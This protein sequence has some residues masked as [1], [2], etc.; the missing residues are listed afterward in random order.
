M[1]QPS[2]VRRALPHYEITSVEADIEESLVQ[3]EVDYEELSVKQLLEQ[4]QD[5]YSVRDPA[6]EQ[7]ARI[8][9][10][11]ITRLSPVYKENNQLELFYD[12]AGLASR[13][14]KN[15][16][17]IVVQHPEVPLQFRLKKVR[18]TKWKVVGNSIAQEIERRQ[19]RKAYLDSISHKNDSDIEETQYLTGFIDALNWVVQQTEVRV[20]YS[21]RGNFVAAVEKTSKE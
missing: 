9:S 11:L 1:S 18:S 12:Q 17:E 5:L 14:S 16:N 10:S 13:N 3:R 8:K 15:P 2:L 6:N 21:L 4:A 20:S 19:T 7:I